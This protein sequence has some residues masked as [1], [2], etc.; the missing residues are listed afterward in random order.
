MPV[1]GVIT[2]SGKKPENDGWCIRQLKKAGITTPCIHINLSDRTGIDELKQILRN[3]P[4]GIP[5]CPE[6]VGKI[7]GKE[8][9]VTWS[10][11]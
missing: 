8:G 11:L 9:N 5:Q 3:T 7:L 6:S 1:I 10:N 2:G 4:S